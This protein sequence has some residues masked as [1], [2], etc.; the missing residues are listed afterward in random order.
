M[1]LSFSEIQTALANLPNFAAKFCQNKNPLNIR[2]EDGT[3]I[4]LQIS[5]YSKRINHDPL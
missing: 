1:Q 5:I 2:V 4:Y 3:E